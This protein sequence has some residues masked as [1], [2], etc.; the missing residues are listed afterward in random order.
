MGLPDTFVRLITLFGL[1]LITFLAIVVQI[2]PPIMLFAAV[3]VIPESPRWLLQKER[4]E[5]AFRA[6]AYTREGFM[7]EEEVT[8]ELRL[9][10][11]AMQE[12][13]ANHRATSYLDCFKGTNLHRT[14]IAMGVQ[15]LQQ[16]Q[17]NSFISTYLVIFLQQ[18]GIGDAQLIAIAF[19]ACN[20]AGCILAFYLSDKVGRRPMLM[21]GALLLALLIWITSGLASWGPKSFAAANGSVAAIMLYVNILA[22]TLEH[23]R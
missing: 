15:C 3:F 20:L 23:H 22:Q 5:E 7:N 4:R 18:V 21:G 16:A 14:C 6:L 13:Q 9:I 17:G 8:Q 1:K 12:E 11:L 2:G 19:Y 10:E